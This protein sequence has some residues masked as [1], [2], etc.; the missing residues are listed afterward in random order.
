MWSRHI[1][2]AAVALCAITASA[3]EPT[4]D[5]LIEWLQSRSNAERKRAQSWLDKQPVESLDRVQPLLSHTSMQVRRVGAWEMIRIIYGARA[6]K[7]QAPRVDHA[8][9]ARFIPDAERLYAEGNRS[10]ASLGGRYLLA[11]IAGSS[12]QSLIALLIEDEREK[13]VADAM[14]AATWMPASVLEDLERLLGSESETV[15]IRAMEAMRMIRRARASWSRELARNPERRKE[16]GKELERVDK[17]ILPGMVRVLRDD[18]SVRVRALAATY[19]GDLRGR[20]ETAVPALMESASK[21]GQ[22]QYACFRAIGRIGPGAS[23]A[24]PLLVEAARESNWNVFG[25]PPVPGDSSPLRVKGILYAM[26]P[27]GLAALE[28]P[29]T[30]E[31]PVVRRSTASRFNCTRRRQ[32][33]LFIAKHYRDPDAQ[34][35][36]ILSLALMRVVARAPETVPYLATG[37]S[38]QRVDVR[39]TAVAALKQLGPPHVRAAMDA[40][41]PAA[42]DEDPEVRRD[43]LIILK[44]L[45]EDLRD[46]ATFAWQF[47]SGD[48]LTEERFAELVGALAEHADEHVRVRIPSILTQYRGRGPE[49]ARALTTQLND[50]SREM[51][52]AAALALVWMG[53]AGAAGVP[54]LARST[55][56]GSVRETT[57]AL[58]ALRRWGVFAEKGILRGLEHPS[59]KVQMS[60]LGALAPDSI[61]ANVP[62]LGELFAGSDAQVRDAIVSRLALAQAPLPGAALPMAKWAIESSVDDRVRRGLEIADQMGT[63]AAPLRRLIE[64]GVFAPK[65]QYRHRGI[66]TL[67]AILVPDTDWV[68][69]TRKRLADRDAEQRA[70]AWTVLSSV[71][72]A[73]AREWI[74]LPEA[75]AAAARDGSRAVRLA[76]C[77]VIRLLP[78]GAQ[79]DSLMK[80]LADADTGVRDAAMRQLGLLGSGADLYMARLRASLAAMPLAR[81]LAWVGALA[82]IGP[83]ARKDLE[84]LLAE[85][86]NK[87]IDALFWALDTSF[88][89][90]AW[91]EQAR[92]DRESALAAASR[93]FAV[94][95]RP[96]PRVS[97][98]MLLCAHAEDPPEEARKL[99]LDAFQTSVGQ[100]ATRALYSLLKAGAPWPTGFGAAIVAAAAKRDWPERY[101]APLS[102]P[103][104]WLDAL[105]HV[106]PA[107]LAEWVFTKPEGRAVMA[108]LALGELGPRG[109]AALPNVR[110]ALATKQHRLHALALVAALKKA[111]APAV[112]VL[113]PFLREGSSRERQLALNALAA[114]GP[115]AMGTEADVRKLYEQGK[116][117]P[118]ALRALVG[119]GVRD[120]VDLLRTALRDPNSAARRDACRLLAG[121][122]PEARPALPDLRNV[123]MGP[124][125]RSASRHEWMLAPD[126]PFADRQLGEFRANSTRNAAAQAIGAQGSVASAALAD[127][128]TLAR[129]P[130]FIH[131]YYVST[132]MWQLERRGI[133]AVR[134]LARGLQSSQRARRGFGYSGDLNAI[135]TRTIDER[136]LRLLTQRYPGEARLV[137]DYDAYLDN[138]NPSFRLLAAAGLAR[139]GSSAV[140]AL[141][142][143]LGSNDAVHRQLAMGALAALGPA[144]KPAVEDLVHHAAQGATEADRSTA[145]EALA[146]I[147]R[148]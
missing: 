5:E 72:P 118:F 30:H 56:E 19:C 138:G 146:A 117:R 18:P 94:E 86:D 50:P 141:R 80:L 84:R 131:P 75:W 73:L 45:G 91:E 104:P 27:K 35:R 107:R 13:L 121:L 77:Q 106:D 22:L 125:A 126:A 20:A 64:A 136:G 116:E 74:W 24:I 16:L 39:R 89:I 88:S 41:R 97:L 95:T 14:R 119:M 58:K 52:R 113:V 32:D 37:L 132:A 120:R 44:K 11:A 15:R 68:L 42:R 48:A 87:T 29:M 8:K 78:R 49:V 81:R 140:P 133:P 98:A 134:I 129:L 60:A 90:G 1:A 115:G 31:D 65:P 23:G 67:R 110:R 61:V 71:D 109:V 59:Q 105:V 102:G 147:R 57:E 111:G 70:A 85:G 130:N 82:A 17:S 53:P 108:H 55:N 101:V 33:A 123:L 66:L 122:G 26:G 28:E 3:D 10:S 114:I 92:P 69:S 34:V 135:R 144:A 4:L 6:P 83:P 100:P 79:G 96:D 128:R 2:A 21:G 62:L 99:T 127:L 36:K 46:V 40:L 9:L 47:K 93:R 112:P 7:G 12:K 54:V 142:L 51:R 145:Q 124:D 38:D 103:Q 25:L 43:A 143:R 139:V 63:R 148:N 137:P 76:A